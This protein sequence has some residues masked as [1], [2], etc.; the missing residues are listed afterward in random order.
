VGKRLSCKTVLSQSQS[1]RARGDW[2][3]GWWWYERGNLREVLVSP[4][5]AKS[6]CVDDDLQWEPTWGNHELHIGG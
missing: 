6:T 1:M 2:R 5:A 3:Y 4:A